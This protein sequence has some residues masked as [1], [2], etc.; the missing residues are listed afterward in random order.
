MQTCLGLLVITC[1]SPCTS[2]RVLRTAAEF[3]LLETTGRWTCSFAIGSPWQLLKDCLGT[4]I[5]T[6]QVSELFNPLITLLINNKM[7]I[8]Q[9]LSFL[10]SRDN[11]SSSFRYKTLFCTPRLGFHWLVE[12]VPHA[13][14]NCRV[15]CRSCDEWL[16]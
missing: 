2:F 13:T 14:V 16:A 7:Y 3:A 5:R 1:L 4:E 11:W 12:A 8:P 6:L 15:A 10:I 9:C